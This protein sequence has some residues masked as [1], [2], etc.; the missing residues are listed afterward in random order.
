MLDFILQWC[1]NHFV[2]GGFLHTM[3]WHSLMK[4][5]V[6]YVLP[7]IITLNQEAIV[8]LITWSP[9]ADVNCSTSSRY[10]WLTHCSPWGLSSDDALLENWWIPTL[11]YYSILLWLSSHDS[12]TGQLEIM[13]DIKHLNSGGLLNSV[14]RQWK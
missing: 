1:C 11:N 4:G 14:W 13:L 3:L 5:C 9:M 8:L 7:Y 12:L 2:S 10:S 6:R